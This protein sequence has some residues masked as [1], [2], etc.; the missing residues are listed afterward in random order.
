MI[1][2][3]PHSRQSLSIFSP[4]SSSSPATW[5]IFIHGGAWRDPSN[6]FN[7]GKTLLDAVN[8][9]FPTVATAAINYRLSP[10]ASHPDFIN[11]LNAAIAAINAVHPIKN[12]IL[13]GH[14]AGTHIATQLFINPNELAFKCSAIIGIAGIYSI[15]LLTVENPGYADFIVPAFGKDSSLW[16][17][18]SIAPYKHK[19]PNHVHLVVVAS[20]QDELLDSRIQPPNAVDVYSKLLGQDHVHYRLTKGRHD[21]TY[22][23]PETIEIVSEWVQKCL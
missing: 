2:Y 10:T 22:S 23:H 18:P 11:D 4:P 6:S 8:T 13:V 16:D 14:S 17:S 3:G 19:W 12:F 21:E 5:V 7:D 20:N 1:S 9:R 15:P